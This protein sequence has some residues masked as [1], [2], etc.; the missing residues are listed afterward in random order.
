MIFAPRVFDV[1]T[2]QGL[3]KIENKS[4][5]SYRIFVS[6]AFDGWTICE[7]SGEGARGTSLSASCCYKFSHAREPDNSSRHDQ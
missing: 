7:S 4:G 6:K 1:Q 2:G 3:K 5:V